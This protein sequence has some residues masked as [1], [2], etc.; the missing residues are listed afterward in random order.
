MVQA[1]IAHLRPAWTGGRLDTLRLDLRFALRAF[2]RSPGFTAVAVLTLALGIGANTAIFSIVR[3]MLLEPLPYRDADRL[4]FIWLGQ[5]VVGL[6][7][8]LAG[9]D[10]RDLREG[11]T[12]FDGFAGIWASGTIT[13]TGGSD[14][15][16]LRGALVTTN[17]FDVL[18]SE[19]AL[20]RTFRRGDAAPGAVPTILLGWDLFQRRF[21]GDP[22]IVGRTIEV[23]DSRAT[24]VGVMPAGWRLLLPAD[25]AVPDRLQAFAPFWPELEEGPRGNLFL[26]VI[27]RMRPGV[28]VAAA[29][30]DVAAVGRRIGR[31]TGRTRT[32]TTIGLQSDQVREIRGPLL[33]LFAG[34]AIL[35]LI[36]CVN[37]AGLIVARTA[38]R[39]GEM[40]LRG[41]LGASPGQ[42]VRLF[43]VEG[44]VLA[45]A[46]GAA[47]LLAGC[48]ALRGLQAAAPP[49]LRRLDSADMDLAAFLFALALAVG[50]GLLCGAA[51]RA[52]AGRRPGAQTLQPRQ[53]TNSAPLHRRVRATLVI[54][55]VA[56]SVL[57]LVGAGLLVR[58]FA[59]VVRVNPGF[60]TDG[61][62]TFRLAVPDRYGSPEA[63]NAFAGEL[64][65]RLAALP[66]VTGVGAIS[67][68]PYDDMPNWSLLYAA[69]API[70][71]DAPSVDAR[72]IST[73]LLETLGVPLLEGRFF[74][75]DDDAA[76]NLVAIVDERLA[77]DLWPGRSAVGQQ[78]STSVAGMNA[79][80][81]SPARVTVVGVVRHLR[82]RSL[83]EELRPQIFFPWRI[84]QRNPT[85]FV[86]ATTRDPAALAAEARAVVRSLDG[87][88]AI[89]DVR[90]LRG[91]LDDA[92]SAR[93]F[94]MLL[95]AAF[96][97]LALV[98]TTVGVYAVLAYAVA[99]RRQEIGIRGALGASAGDLVRGVLREGVGLSLAGCAA[100]LALAA[101][102]ARRRCSPR[103]RCAAI[104]RDSQRWNDATASRRDSVPRAY[105]R[106]LAPAMPGAIVAPVLSKKMVLRTSVA[107]DRCPVA[108]TVVGCAS[109]K[110]A[111]T[112]SAAAPLQVLEAAVT[113]TA[114]ASGWRV[115]T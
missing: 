16:Q 81:P 26:R 75:D 34:V 46:G 87:R 89:Y 60:R 10:L 111:E 80:I 45:L 77:R 19:P 59:A 31:E 32:F 15:E 64:Q 14:P 91:Y 51:T 68:L 86:L 112:A 106:A 90:P 40:A 93:R 17:F 33:A 107:N 56:L 52:A 7:G 74:S 58:A 29:G 110:Y 28:A 44:L 61:Q 115:T 54:V 73:G 108:P 76:A 25:A 95:A 67:H 55:Q 5:N 35:L 6:R 70:P 63:F 27:G 3:A 43:L 4:V 13:L 11:T 94:T 42:L 38:A 100:G 69:Q 109:A 114:L 9:P 1:V 47:G 39:Q 83:I 105:C 36:A 78:L 41:A 85:A 104:S 98:L 103:R 96:A 20:G 2:L 53:R 72:A 62:L 65:Q 8:P 99:Q 30:E 101:A 18:G 50:A 37:V 88:V 71:P 92:R 102:G 113:A 57:L 23:N 66:G 84:A 12:T 79:G 48:A 49:S 97:L 21:G 82:L 24:V 22:S